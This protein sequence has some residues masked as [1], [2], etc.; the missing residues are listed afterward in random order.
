MTRLWFIQV[1][2]CGH[3]SE[4][5]GSR[6]ANLEFY[7]VSEDHESAARV[8]LIH[9]CSLHHP[10]AGPRMLYDLGDNR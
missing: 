10:D 5:E 4:G 8:S 2:E 3:G 6:G 9:C 7:P 1:K